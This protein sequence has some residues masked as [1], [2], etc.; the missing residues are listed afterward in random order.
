MTWAVCLEPCIGTRHRDRKA[1]AGILSRLQI[2]RSI[3]NELRT[4]MSNGPLLPGHLPSL[5]YLD[6]MIRESLGL[7]PTLPVVAR[8]LKAPVALGGYTLPKGVLSR[9][10]PATR[11][12]QLG[13]ASRPCGPLRTSPHPL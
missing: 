7:R 5:V 13:E 1:G 9:L 8:L 3:D 6:A 11:F 4:T 2:L 10:P 12:T